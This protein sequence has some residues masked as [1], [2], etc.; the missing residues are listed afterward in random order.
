MDPINTLIIGTR[1]VSCYIKLTRQS[2]L[3]GDGPVWWDFPRT[4]R[5]FEFLLWY[6]F[7]TSLRR[8]DG[9]R[10]P[11]LLHILLSCRWY[12]FQNAPCKDKDITQQWL[13]WG[14]GVAQGHSAV[15]AN[16]AAAWQL[17]K[18]WLCCFSSSLF[19][20]YLCLKCHCGLV[21][22]RTLVVTT[23]KANGKGKKILH[24]TPK[25]RSIPFL[26]QKCK[27]KSIYGLQSVYT[28]EFA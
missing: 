4:G 6:S 24:M 12:L 8:W 13:A 11:Y 23:V 19:F 21:F 27:K 28:V 5:H 9:R 25:F 7:H 16:M 15:E 20:C 2:F 3:W 10:A 1:H 22:D 14:V 26:L 18:S 17:V